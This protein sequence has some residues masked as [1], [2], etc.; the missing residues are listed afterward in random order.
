MRWLMHWF[1]RP[2]AS[3]E[4]SLDATERAM[5]KLTP[6][7]EARTEA[8]QRRAEMSRAVQREI[9]ARLRQLDDWG[10]VWGKDAGDGR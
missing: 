3:S 8:V 2:P 10:A 9:E 5:Q 1:S 7:L 6:W 4:Q